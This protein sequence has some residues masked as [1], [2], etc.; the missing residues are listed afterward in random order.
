MPHRGLWH[1]L[2]LKVYKLIFD[3]IVIKRLEAVIWKA[4]RENSDHDRGTSLLGACDAELS[5]PFAIVFVSPHVPTATIY[6]NL[7]DLRQ[8]DLLIGLT[9]TGIVKFAG[10]F[11]AVV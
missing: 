6:F 3:C 10:E 5:L 4:V 2:N 9:C 11:N 1:P 8:I 7:R